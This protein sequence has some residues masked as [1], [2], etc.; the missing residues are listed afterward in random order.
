MVSK[1]QVSY[2]K[3]LS[4]QKDRE[5]AG[6]FLVEGDKI[7]REWLQSAVKIERVLALPAWLE[8]HREL[9]ARHPE[10]EILPVT[11]S[12]LE[13]MTA[14]Q[15]ANKV[16]L[17]AAMPESF[18]ATAPPADWCLALDEIRDPGNLGTLIRIA[19]WFGIRRLYLSPGCTDI[20]N[21][22]VVQSAMGGHLRV[23]MVRGDLAT[24]LPETGLPVWA[25]TLG[26]E[27]VYEVP[28]PAP[29]GVLLIGNES[30][31]V[32]PELLRIAGRQVAI[33]RS[34]GAESLNAAVS[35]GI[36]CAL[37]LRR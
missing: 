26:G 5:A 21:P 24:L 15:T 18:P 1:A 32:S 30:R 16:L 3:S 23:G 12:E 2:I 11:E 35:A 6:A 13:R 9:L 37:L 8:E 31:G 34:G 25:A 28:A 20:Y 14:L 7:A 27:N 10:T 29:P 4:R 17:V 33:P 19:D 36:L 22:K